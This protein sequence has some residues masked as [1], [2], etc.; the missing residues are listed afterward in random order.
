VIGGRERQIHVHMDPLKLRAAGLTAV[1]V[2]NTLVAQNLTT[3]GGNLE[4]GPQSLTLRIKGRVDSVQ[5]V[6]NLAVRS[7]DGRILRLS[8]VARIEDGAEA[9]ESIARYDGEEAV[10]LSVVKQSGENT[11][12]V[13]DA[14]LARIEGIR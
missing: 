1:D 6:E 10:V 7:E 12:E 2:M 9:V 8:D 4:T 13:V 5:A 3:P 11:I 14:V